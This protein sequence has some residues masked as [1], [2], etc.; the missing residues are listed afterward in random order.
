MTMLRILLAVAALLLFV[1]CSRKFG[2]RKTLGFV[3]LIVT[4]IFPFTL[5]AGL[6]LPFFRSLWHSLS[7]GTRIVAVL[8]AV[9]GGYVAV[10][11]KGAGKVLGWTFS[12]LVAACFVILA[13]FVLVLMLAPAHGA[14]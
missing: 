1:K 8:T 3:A 2:F 11:E 6:A 13:G 7:T 10:K 9:I 12:L 4:L 14:R 5:S